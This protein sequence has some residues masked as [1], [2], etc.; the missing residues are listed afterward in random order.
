MTAVRTGLVAGMV[1]LARSVGSAQAGGMQVGSALE[2]LSNRSGGLVVRLGDVVVKAHPA[3]TDR[4]ALKARLSVAARLD[5][6]LL[7]PLSADLHDVDGRLVTVWPAGEP[8]APDDPDAAPWEAAA[9]LLAALH[10]TPAEPGLEAAGAPAKVGRAV[11]R[12][13]RTVGEVAPVEDAFATLPPWATG[14]APPSGHALVHG[15]WHLGQ[16]VRTTGWRLLDVDDLGVGD[17]AWDLAR[18][19]ALFAAGVLDP[20]AWHRF[21]SAYQ[22]AAGSESDPWPAL[23]VPAKALA[24][25]LAAAGVSD[26]AD[27]RRDLDGFEA[28]LLDTCR[29]IT[30]AGGSPDVS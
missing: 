22:A 8:V 17:P 18:P 30:A 10:A 1:A 13:R 29:R 3:G 24:V 20:D 16:L 23:D 5:P 11:E 26:A 12:L 7:A 4:D 15:D 9:E 14:A 19:A 28:A 27:A 25:Q 21:L 6:L 2:L